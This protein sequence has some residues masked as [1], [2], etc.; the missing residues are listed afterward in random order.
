MTEAEVV[1]WNRLRKSKIK[2]YRF[3]PQ[4]PINK[5]IVDFYCHEALLVVELD[6]EVHKD[7]VV[8]EHDEGREL[9]IEKLGITIIRFSNKEVFE[10]PDKVIEV[11]VTHLKKYKKDI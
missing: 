6:G 1:L 2:E 10:D 11:I 4:H 9:E 8:A 5:F 7:K 3:R